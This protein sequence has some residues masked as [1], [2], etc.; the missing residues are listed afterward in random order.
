MCPEH[1]KRFDICVVCAPSEIKNLGGFFAKDRPW[2]ILD[3]HVSSTGVRT[4]LAAPL[5]TSP[6]D[7][8]RH[9]GVQHSRGVSTLVLDQIQA[10][11]IGWFKSRRGRLS[12]LSVP[13]VERL[14]GTGVLFKKLQY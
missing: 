10:I 8:Y 13:E 1:L 4:R 6:P 12:E 14:L 11:R 9:V 3:E 5:T 2:V 7:G